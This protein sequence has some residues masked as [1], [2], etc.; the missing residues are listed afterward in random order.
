[1]PRLD[2]RGVRDAC[3]VDAP[4]AV[5]DG[6]AELIE[7]GELRRAEINVQQL[8]GS[9]N[10]RQARFGPTHVPIIYRDCRAAI[11]DPLEVLSFRKSTRSAW[12]SWRRN[13]LADC[14][15]VS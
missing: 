12:V 9:L 6:G 8:R 3:Q 13:T 10:Q 5:P 2:L 1:M 15:R 14:Q 7:R 4:I 11:G